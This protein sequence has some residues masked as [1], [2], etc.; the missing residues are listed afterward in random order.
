MAAGFVNQG[1]IISEHI[2]IQAEHFIADSADVNAFN[3]YRAMIRL[4]VFEV[5]RQPH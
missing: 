3:I 5:A 2:V 4:I 1:P